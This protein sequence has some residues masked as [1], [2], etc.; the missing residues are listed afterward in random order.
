MPLFDQGKMTKLVSELR[1][2]VAR[3]TD[4]AKLPKD[5]FLND[6]DKIESTKYHFIVAIESSISCYPVKK[7]RDPSQC[8][9]HPKSAIRTPQNQ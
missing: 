7:Q 9:S 6:P 5:E 1:K 2:S 3:L 8:F 4:I